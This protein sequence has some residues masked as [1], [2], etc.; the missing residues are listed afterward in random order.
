MIESTAVLKTVSQRLT[1]ALREGDELVRWGG[2]E[3]LAIL[4]PLSA[5]QAER[6]VERL[7]ETARL[8]P[9]QWL[10]H[11]I[12]VTIS[13]GYG[14]FPGLGTDQLTLDSANTLVDQVAQRVT[15]LHAVALSLCDGRYPTLGFCYRGA[16]PR[17]ST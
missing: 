2:E 3:F 16:V 1:A 14:I 7:L 17:L 15:G 5:D 12:P 8:T 9:V 13:I 10:G 11:A 4:S 6:T